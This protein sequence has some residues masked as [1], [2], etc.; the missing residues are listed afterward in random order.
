MTRA[1]FRFGLAGV[2]AVGL[3][4]AGAAAPVAVAA[5]A[6]V[7]VPSADP[8]YAPPADLAS[9]APGAILRWRAVAVSGVSDASAVY[10]LLY[11]TTDATGHP[12][13]TVTTLFLPSNPAPGGRDLISG[14]PAEDSL[15]TKCAPSYVLRSGQVSGVGDAGDAESVQSFLQYGWDVE[16]PDYEGPNSEWTVGLLEGYTALDG[17]RAVEHFAP[18]DLEGARTRVATAGYSGGAL[19][20]LWGASLAKSYAPELNIVAAASGGNAPDPVENLAALNGSPLFGTVVGVAVGVNRAFPELHL[21]SILNARG[22]ALAATDGRDGDGCG[23]LVFN[24]P[25]GTV[26]EYSNY[27]TPQALLAAPNV[28]AV[29]AHEDLIGRAAPAAPSLIVNSAQDELAFIGPVNELVDADCAQ[30]AVIDYQTPPGEHVTGDEFFGQYALP[31]IQDRFAGKPAP[32][33]CP[34]GS[35][36]PPTSPPYGTKLTRS[37]VSKREHRA[38]FRFTAAGAVTGFEC[39]LIRPKKAERQTNTKVVFTPCNS[40]RTYT[41]LNGGRYTFEVRAV[42]SAGSDPRPAIKRF[43]I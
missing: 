2:V 42:N 8:F 1:A 19:P 39:A 28:R 3:L 14:F 38:T 16:F 32:D 31:Y 25:G 18:A 17:I 37:L 24:A 11:R 5:S 41:H 22:R 12:I 6:A 23:G 10:Q 34:A 33:T 7:P 29:F 27:P 20:T 4:G 30:G 26:A 43:A 36:K 21:D 40:P 9:D 13:A 15:S 35:R